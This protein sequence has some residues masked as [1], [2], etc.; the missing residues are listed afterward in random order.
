M[1]IYVTCAEGLNYINRNCKVAPTRNRPLRHKELR[2][3]PH[4]V[5]WKTVG[6]AE[7]LRIGGLSWSGIRTD[8]IAV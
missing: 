2:D 7:L 8:A 5:H 6:A 1:W 3:G 4:C